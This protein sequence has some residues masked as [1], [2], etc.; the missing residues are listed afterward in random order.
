MVGFSTLLSGYFPF[1]FGTLIGIFLGR[2]EAY[3]ETSFCFSYF[4]SNMF[5]VFPPKRVKLV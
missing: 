1:T 5:L 4:L 3:K 2:L